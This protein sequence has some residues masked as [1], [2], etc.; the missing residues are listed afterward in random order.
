ML[1]FVWLLIYIIFAEKMQKQLKYNE[2][3]NE[4]KCPCKYIQLA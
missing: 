4:S 2:T 3:N 1:R